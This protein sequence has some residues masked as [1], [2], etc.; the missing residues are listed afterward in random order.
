MPN[1]GISFKSPIFL[2]FFPEPFPKVSQAKT[3]VTVAI[4]LTGHRNGYLNGKFLLFQ[5]NH[6]YTEAYLELVML[7]CNHLTKK[8]HREK[9]YTS[10]RNDH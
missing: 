2:S 3:P 7:Y 6:F 9:K 8:T 5:S 10:R 1:M 4:S